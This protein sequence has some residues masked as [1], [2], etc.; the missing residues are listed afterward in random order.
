MKGLKVS[1]FDPP[2]RMSNCKGFFFEKII[3]AISL[4]KTEIKLPLNIQSVAKD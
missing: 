2:S 1:F 4:R 3:F